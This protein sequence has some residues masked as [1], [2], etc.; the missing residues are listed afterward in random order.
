[1]EQTEHTAGAFDIRVIIAGLI[2]TYGV[3]LV[4]LG[5]FATSAEDLTRADGL[6]INLWAG[7][8]MVAVAVL[9][10]AW[11]RWRPIVVAEDSETA[12]EPPPSGR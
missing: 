11:A 7:A 12:D 6:N 1:M 4:A 8:G 5:L 2:G 9:F 3:V 10:V